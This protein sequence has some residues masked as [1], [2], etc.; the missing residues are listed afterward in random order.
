MHPFQ[1]ASVDSGADGTATTFPP[2]PPKLSRPRS[3]RSRCQAQG[4]RLCNRWS[5]S[6]FYLSKLLLSDHLQYLYNLQLSLQVFKA[7]S[8]SAYHMHIQPL[9]SQKHYALSWSHQISAAMIASV[10]ETRVIHHTM[11]VRVSNSITPWQPDTFL[12]LYSRHVLKMYGWPPVCSL[13]WSWLL[14]LCYL[15]KMLPV[16]AF[17]KSRL[18]I[19]IWSSISMNWCLTTSCLLL[20]RDRNKMRVQSSTKLVTHH[21]NHLLMPNE[22][23]MMRG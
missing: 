12:V 20:Q 23:Q 17:P 1:D 7:S 16:I 5:N 6:Y 2:C 9:I 13:K 15:D 21:T 14:L 8:R 18:W 10:L 22:K 4:F 19:L 3:T 11:S